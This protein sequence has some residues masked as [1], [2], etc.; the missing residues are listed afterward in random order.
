M[1][2]NECLFMNSELQPLVLFSIL[3]QVML[4]SYPT[5]RKTRALA[6]QKLH[7]LRIETLDLK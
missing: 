5:S 3:N 1:N 7:K 6:N 4:K 2:T